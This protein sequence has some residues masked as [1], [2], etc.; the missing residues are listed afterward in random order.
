MSKKL[1]KFK[2]NAIFF[3]GISATLLPAM[4][5]A[6]WSIIELGN[7]GG[8]HTE[9]RGINDF[10]QVVG[11]SYI[12]GDLYSHAF[13]T[14]PNGIG[15]TDLGT[16]GGLNSEAS[17]INN[18]GQVAGTA[19][20][21]GDLYSH[22]HAFITGTNGMGMSD[23]GTLGGLYSGATSINDSGQVVGGSYTSDGSLRPFITGTNGVGMT[24]LGSLGGSYSIAFDINNSGQVVGY[25]STNNGNYH[26]FIT[27]TNGVDMTDLGALKGYRNSF[28]QDINDSGQVTGMSY[29]TSLDYSILYYRSFITG[30][31]G[32]NMTDLGTL[33]GPVSNPTDINDLGQVVG[34]SRIDDN[35]NH[36][37]AF[38]YT[39]GGMIDLSLLDSVIAAGWIELIPIDINNN[40]QIVGYGK[41]ASD[42]SHLQSFLLSFSFDTI[43]TP[44]PVFIPPMPSDISL[45]PEPKIYAMLL[46]GLS[47]L[48]FMA[49]RRKD[50]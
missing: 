26:A 34:T 13:I 18:S 36:N 29:S 17:S 47:L 40:G 46:T 33:G 35:P 4:A 14:G 41:L 6:D 30:P 44:N 37:H 2:R 11:S 27:G 43:F 9:A 3:V 5:S 1:S 24:D 8:V 39:D 32:T 19:R 23:L 45:I 21:A 12:A 22:S 48:S 42:P 7:L 38:L 25:S 10:G 28:A 31:D 20:I 49:R 50:V 16:L 15:M